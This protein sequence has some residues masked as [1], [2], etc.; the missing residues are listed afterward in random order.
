M[1]NP[2][3]YTPQLNA[4]QLKA[5][6]VEDDEGDY[7][8][9]TGITLTMMYAQR[10]G[11]M[12][13]VFRK[14]VEVFDR[15]ILPKKLNSYKRT[16]W[17]NY[18]PKHLNRLLNTF[19]SNEKYGEEVVLAILDGHFQYFGEF[20][21]RF[22]GAANESGTSF[23]HTDTSVAYF[24]LPIDEFLR[25]G[26]DHLIAFVS[27]VSN[28]APFAH[29]MCGYTF[30]YFHRSEDS[31]IDY[32]MGAMAQRFIAVHPFRDHWEWRCRHFLPNVNWMT[33]LGGE[34]QEKMGGF[35]AIRAALSAQVDCMPL[36]HG[37]LLMAGQEPPL[38]DINAQ[39]PDIGPLRELAR[40]LQP[41]LL[42]RETQFNNILNSL[43]DDDDDAYRWLDRFERPLLGGQ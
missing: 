12:L 13:P 10:M 43:F 39:A 32:W 20:G 30:K 14:M 34:L 23:R 40:Y 6:R 33:L 41:L 25:V 28:L 16:D 7:Y 31:D 4:E 19:T 2:P 1:T 17:R 18:T 29:G 8:A 42:P 22:I 3:I 38:G 36:S 35:P 9:A 37:C 24:E 11:E 15:Y 21:L 27:E 26:K 5:L